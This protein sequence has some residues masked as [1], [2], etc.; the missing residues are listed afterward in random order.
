MLNITL[1]LFNMSETEFCF[2]CKTT[3]HYLEKCSNTSNVNSIETNEENNEEN[4]YHNDNNTINTDLER[5]QATTSLIINSV[6]MTKSIPLCHKGIDSYL[7]IIL[8]CKPLIEDPNDLKLSRVNVNWG[9]FNYKVECKLCGSKSDNIFQI[10]H[11]DKC[12]YYH[13]TSYPKKPCI[14]NTCKNHALNNNPQCIDCFRKIT[15]QCLKCGGP[16]VDNKGNAYSSW[17]KYC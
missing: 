3:H 6:T 13:A 12:E 8:S 14:T 10:K 4:N 9:N 7:R 16:K 1:V 15:K 5:K 17:C 2:T 11:L